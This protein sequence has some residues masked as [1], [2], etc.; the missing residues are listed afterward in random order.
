MK[1]KLCF[2][3]ITILFCTTVFSQTDYS[4]DTTK[5]GKPVNTRIVG[6]NWLIAIWNQEDH[7]ISVMY[8]DTRKRVGEPEKQSLFVPTDPTVTKPASKY[9]PKT[10]MQNDIAL[11]GPPNNKTTYQDG[12]YY[13]ITLTW[14]CAYG[15][16]RDISYTKEGKRDNVFTSSC[17]EI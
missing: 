16:Y 7:A 4:A 6:N 14:H 9:T 15:S 12:D 8:D 13:R 10:D 3:S 11:Y 1:T 2:I 5:W 17:L